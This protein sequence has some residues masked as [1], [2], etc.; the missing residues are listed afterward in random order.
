MGALNR[1]DVAEIDRN[2]ECYNA[3][4][5]SAALSFDNPDAD[6]DMSQEDEA[7][8]V[9][10][11]G[12][13]FSPTE[14]DFAKEEPK[15]AGD[16]GDVDARIKRVLAAKALHGLPQRRK[17]EAKQPPQATDYT[18]RAL[19]TRAEQK[20]MKRIES[21]AAKK[22]QT[23]QR[24]ASAEAVAAL[25]QQPELTHEV[26]HPAGAAEGT[27]HKPHESHD[28]RTFTTSTAVIIYCDHCG[29]WQRHDAGRS[30]L[31]GEC[32]KIKEGSKSGLKLL[33]HKIIPE[34]GAVLP[35]SVKTKGGKRC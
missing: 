25:V 34:K 35:A 18:A 7:G 8:Y 31:A 6:V 21:E 26:N 33:R 16:E 3:L 22:K 23:I 17:L 19:V 20:R 27:R 29:K 4:A 12:L 15:S 13:T 28:M 10:T 14:E 24:A 2:V 30:K 1:R 5:M 32:Q 11:E 9:E